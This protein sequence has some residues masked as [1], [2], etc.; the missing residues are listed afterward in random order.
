M[1]IVH[2]PSEA[3]LIAH[4][5]GNMDAA[6][7]TVIAIHADMCPRCRGDLVLAEVIGGQLLAGLAPAALAP[8]ALSRAL[9]RL[10]AVP[11]DTTAAEPN[12]Q[13]RSRLGF[14]L[15]AALRGYGIGRWRWLAPGIRFVPV[16]RRSSRAGLDDRPRAQSA[17]HLFKIAPGTAMP[18]H[19]HGGSEFTCVLAGSYDDAT[20]R[21]AA[22]DFAETAEDLEHRPVADSRTGC[23]CVIA[24]EAKLR[25]RG[26]I[27]R[28]LQPVL[29]F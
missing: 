23:I 19:R 17:L 5:A 21:F 12:S 27:A 14:D 29:G 13:V 10:G 11:D 2:H 28:L 22:G 15:P 4:A 24:S 18:G 9:G 6:S 1:T 16:L 7:A 26:P 20:G 3:T 25:F 8:D